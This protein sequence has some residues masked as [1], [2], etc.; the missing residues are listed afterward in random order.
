MHKLSLRITA[1][2]Q[3]DIILISGE[4]ERKYAVFFYTFVSLGQ[5]MFEKKTGNGG[6]R[7]AYDVSLDK[8]N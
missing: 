5:K 8:S 4:V 7:V 1:L 6:G 3:P 2:S